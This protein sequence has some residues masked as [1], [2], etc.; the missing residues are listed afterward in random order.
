METTFLDGV[1]LSTAI[2]MVA[3]GLVC[4]GYAALWA[5]NKVIAII[6]K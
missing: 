2:P 4:T 1:T 5:V 3:A 6:K